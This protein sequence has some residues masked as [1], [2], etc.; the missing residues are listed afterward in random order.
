MKKEQRLS[1]AQKVTGAVLALSY[2]LAVYSAIR[3]QLVP[4]KYL[5]II[6]P[7]TTFVIAWLVFVHFKKILPLKKSIALIVFSLL[8]TAAN[9]YIYSAATATSSFLGALQEGNSTFEE[10][11]IIAKKDRHIALKS[12]S[13]RYQGL[14]KS[15]TNTELVTVELKKRTTAERKDYDSLTDITNALDSKQTDTSVLKS[16]YVELLKESNN[17]FYKSIEVLDTFKIKVEKNTNS[18]TAD[19]A[20]PFI[21]YISG[22]D[23][24]GDVASVSRSDVNIL[25]VVNPQ[26]HKILLVNTPRDY[27]VQLHG[28]TG[29]KDKLTHAGIY[30]IDTSTQTLEDLYGAQIDYYLRVNFTSLVTIVDALGGVNVYSDY[31]FKSFSAG[32]NTLNGKQAL[33]F[34]RERY[35]FAEGDR[36]RGKNQQRVIEAIIAKMNDPK[37]LVNYRAILGSLQGALQTNMGPDKIS[38]I[39]NKQLNDLSKWQ[40]ESISVDGTGKKAS[41]YSMG[42]MELYVMEPDMN[43]VNAAKQKIIQYQ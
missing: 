27:Y 19:I 39:I 10:Y 15:D 31:S 13:N 22:I 34:S 18:G 42:A 6:L 14:L 11:S 41:T 43:S 8:V 32:Y 30:G 12:S 23:T 40:V 28:A 17:A 26:T 38:A 24:Y 16:S 21:M 1:L 5:L 9:S 33:E 7:I 37:S 35:S 29:V 4:T 36:T 2:L 20:K 3:T 25:V